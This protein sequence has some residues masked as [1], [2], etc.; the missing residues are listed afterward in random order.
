MAFSKKL[1]WALLALRLMFGAGMLYGHGLR[2]LDRLFGDAEIKFADPF[3]I[4]PVPSLALVV[5]AEVVC[6][7]LLVLG[8]FTRW[9]TIPLI[10]AMLVAVF[11]AHGSD[12]FSDKEMGLLYLTA[13]VSIA[14]AGPGW[15]SVDAQWKA[16]K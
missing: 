2:K 5:F 7:A 9:A 15:Y 16:R 1:D 12:P 13:Y 14:L 6:A 4:G 3:G 11:Y 8:L 10:I